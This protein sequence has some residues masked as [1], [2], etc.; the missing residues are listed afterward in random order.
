ML[1]EKDLATMSLITAQGLKEQLMMQETQILTLVRPGEL[2]LSTQIAMKKARLDEIAQDL[3]S[4]ID[5]L[6]LTEVNLEW[7]Q[8]RT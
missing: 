3:M 6:S 8:V 7:M 4:E 5:A 1:T 2:S